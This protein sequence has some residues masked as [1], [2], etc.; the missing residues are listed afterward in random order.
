LLAIAMVGAAMAGC[1]GSSGSPLSAGGAPNAG[2]GGGPNQIGTAFVRIIN[3]SPDF[4]AIDV[5]VDNTRVW[6]NVPYANFNGKAGGVGTAP[7]YVTSVLAVPLSPTAHNIA[8]Y[9]A[10][11]AAG[12]ATQ[13]AA[14]TT[15]PGASRT[16]IVIAD[17][18]Y[19]AL[20]VA[21]QAIPFTEPILVAPPGGADNVVFHHASPSGATGTI[22]VGTLA[23]KV[24]SSSNTIT[25]TCKGQVTFSNPP[26]PQSIKVLPLVNSGGAPIG[27]Y[28]GTVSSTGTSACKNPVAEFFPATS[29]TPPPPSLGGYPNSGIVYPTPAPNPPGQPSPPP[30]DCD[31]TLPPTCSGAAPEAL[32]ALPNLSLYAIDAAPVPPATTP[33]VTILGVFDSNTQ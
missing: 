10:G 32:A 2:N 31:S 30:F 6:Q 9:A 29:A 13:Q 22:A 7:F 15:A 24:G 4:G 5:Y 19:G 21:L 27:F 33:G 26:T 8:V 11:A 20:P 28:V 12:N 3:G 23:V 1:S 14:V 25:P 16:T 17:K 18:V